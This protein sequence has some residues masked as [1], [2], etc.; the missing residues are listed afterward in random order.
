MKTYILLTLCLF[1]G[2]SLSAQVVTQKEMAMSLGNQIGFVVD[3]E[4]ADDGLAEDVWKEYLKEYCKVKRNKKA[5]E[6]YCEDCKVSLLSTSPMQVTLKLDERKEM[7][8]AS[9]FFDTGSS[10][11]SSEAD[12]SMAESVEKFMYNYALEVKRS[13][14]ENDLKEQEKELKNFNKDQEKLE[15]LNKGFHKD[16]EKAKKQIVEAE[17]NIEK[18]LKEQEAK[19]IEIKSQLKL[20]EGITGRLNSVGK[21]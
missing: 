19:Q 17:E 20:V 10:F 7:T 15:K 6:Y 9:A 3:L 21:N 18:N 16:I 13:V 8:V 1:F 12:G 2:F 4:G 14:I 5:D 11:I